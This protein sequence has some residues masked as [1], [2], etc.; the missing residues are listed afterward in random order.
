MDN[1]VYERRPKKVYR[2][3]VWIAE[4]PYDKTCIQGGCRPVLVISNNA[5]NK[6]FNDI[7][8]V[9]YI[10]YFKSSRKSYSKV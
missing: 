8:S 4:L 9:I 6:Y 2:G 7:K 10:L 3:E 1:K 5:C